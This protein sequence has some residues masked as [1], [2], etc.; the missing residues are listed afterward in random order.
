VLQSYPS[1][2]TERNRYRFGKALHG[3]PIRDDDALWAREIFV[4]QVATALHEVATGA[5]ARFLDL[6]DAMAGHEVCARGITKAQEWVSGLR[7]DLRQLG[8]GAG[9]QLV[10]QS[11]HP[12]ALGHAQLGRCL[13]AFAASA[14]RAANC[15]GNGGIPRPFTARV[16]EQSRFVPLVPRDGP[17]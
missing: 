7:I 5:G 11:L 13:T 16:P 14:D 4:P 17:A 15:R 6:R 8:T 1:P 3:C 12:N 2:V 9:R 10:Q